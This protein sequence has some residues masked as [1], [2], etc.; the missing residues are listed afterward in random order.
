MKLHAYYRNVAIINLD[1][2]NDN[3]PYDCALD[4]SE[5]ITIDDAMQS[6][7]LGPNGA[8]V[9][10]LKYLLTNF[11]WLLEKLNALGGW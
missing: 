5:L 2:A 8:M 7:K 6:L 4:I 3:L 1:P 10:C 11:D 9:Y